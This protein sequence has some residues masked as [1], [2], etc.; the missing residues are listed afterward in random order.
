MNNKRKNSVVT[1]I[2][3]LVLLIMS[4]GLYIFNKDLQILIATIFGSLFLQSFA[5]MMENQEQIITEL[6][7]NK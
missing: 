6:Q 3:A 4:I 2:V 7:K 5:M 1:K